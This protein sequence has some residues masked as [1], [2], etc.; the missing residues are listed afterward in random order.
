VPIQEA[1]DHSW[2]MTGKPEANFSIADY[3]GAIA[4]C[5]LGDCLRRLTVSLLEGSRD[6][7]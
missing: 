5:P 2:R 4:V 7:R 3:P 6:E 1:L